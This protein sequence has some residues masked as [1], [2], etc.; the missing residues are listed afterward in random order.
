MVIVS[1]DNEE[2]VQSPAIDQWAAAL[3]CV[4]E[5]E[6]SSGRRRAV[7]VLQQRALAVRMW[8]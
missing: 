2:E 4:T 3:A 1:E 6:K 7:A 5:E 8:L